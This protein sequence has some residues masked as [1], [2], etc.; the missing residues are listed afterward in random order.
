MY[1]SASESTLKTSSFIITG[2]DDQKTRNYEALHGM[3]DFVGF[4]SFAQ[5]MTADLE[6]FH[7]E[8]YEGLWLAMESEYGSKI[9]APFKARASSTQPVVPKTSFPPPP[10]QLAPQV[11]NPDA[12]VDEGAMAPRLEGDVLL[13]THLRSFEQKLSWSKHELRLL[14]MLTEVVRR[15]LEPVTY[16]WELHLL[17]CHLRAATWMSHNTFN[18]YM[19]VL[20]PK[21]CDLL[22]LLGFTKQIFVKTLTGKTITLNVESSDTIES[23]KVKIQDKIGIPPDQQRLIFSGR[24]LDNDRHLSDYDIQRESTLHLM[25]SLKG[26]STE[27]RGLSTYDVFGCGL[28]LKDFTD[29]V[30]TDSVKTDP[31][32]TDPV[33]GSTVRWEFC[34]EGMYTYEH[35]V[36]VTCTACPVQHEIDHLWKEKIK[37]EI[38]EEMKKG[39]LV[40]PIWTNYDLVNGKLRPICSHL[41]PSWMLCSKCPSCPTSNWLTATTSEQRLKVLADNLSHEKGKMLTKQLFKWSLFDYVGGKMIYR[42]TDKNQSPE[43]TAGQVWTAG[44]PLPFG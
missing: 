13:E 24:Q 37:E 16:A 2:T 42:E 25:L 17:L 9:V 31:V 23:V 44:M 41:L 19:T 39:R 26:G 36:V 6:A 38:W 33:C 28:S 27:T 43:F 40:N 34:K 30:K 12:P 11:Y 4:S 3:L 18:D 1:K 22:L 35:D 14:E 32:K 29:P 10:L 8:N 20:R 15:K 7:G 21:V 5:Q